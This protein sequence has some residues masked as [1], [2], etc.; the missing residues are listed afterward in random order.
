MKNA[1]IATGLA[2]AAA[3][4]LT[5]TDASAKERDKDEGSGRSYTPPKTFAVANVFTGDLS[6][7]IRVGRT[8]VFLTKKT[9]LYGTEKG[10]LPAG[11]H[12]GREPIYVSGYVGHDGQLRATMVIVRQGKT[13]GRKRVA[14]VDSDEGS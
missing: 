14:P 2:V 3:L 5:V 10:R 1:F 7:E 12:V 9:T 13:S 11:Y 6:G 4:A 8:K